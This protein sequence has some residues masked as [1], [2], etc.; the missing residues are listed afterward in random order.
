MED[1]LI[2]NRINMI[3]EGTNK[4]F[5]AEFETGYAVL[6]DHQYFEGY[7][8][9]LGKEHKRELHELDSGYKQKFLVE[10]SIV[11]E[12]VH[13]A[14]QP[15]KLNYELL[16]NG[17]SHMHWHI[18]P[19]QITEPNPAQPVWL[20]PR[21]VMYADSNRPGEE[22]LAELKQALLIELNKLAAIS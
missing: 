1:C 4:Y 22:R 18:F 9:F 13:N 19:R 10:M 15:L 8:L 14:F 17:D 21:E 11:A 2:C 16:G 12:A 7:T 20:T 6:G 5:V 3:K